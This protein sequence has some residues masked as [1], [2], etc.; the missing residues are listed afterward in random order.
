[1]KKVILS[2][3][4]AVYCCQALAGIGQGTIAKIESGPLYGNK[5]FITIEGSVTGQP[6]CWAS[7]N[8]HFAFD[9]SATGGKNLLASIMLA[10]AT[11]QSVV[12]SGYDACTLYGGIEDL[13]WFRIE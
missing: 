1:M 3:L 13:R 7:G 12:I 9:S 10:K 4:L 11:K 8:Y 6:T 2:A 5:V